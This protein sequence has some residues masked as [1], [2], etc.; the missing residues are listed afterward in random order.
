[1]KE[2]VQE[3][4]SAKQA[5]IDALKR[6]VRQLEAVV[7]AQQPIASAAPEVRPA[8]EPA[9]PVGAYSQ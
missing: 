6:R 7:Q 1:V 5:E 2:L 8:P 9:K 4:L 3:A